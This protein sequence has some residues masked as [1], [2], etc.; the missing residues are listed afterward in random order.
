M[1]TGRQELFVQIRLILSRSNVEDLSIV[2]FSFIL[3]AIDGDQE[4]FIDYV[5][6]LKLISFG[7]GLESSVSNI[8]FETFNLYLS[9]SNVQ[10]ISIPHLYTA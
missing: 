4:I 6:G 2:L 3:G 5:D 10:N 7:S 8:V 9:F 1:L